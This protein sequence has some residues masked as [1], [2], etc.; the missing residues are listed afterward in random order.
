[1]EKY[2]LQV[3][4]KDAANFI[5]KARKDMIID[6][7]YLTDSDLNFVYIPLK[8]YQNGAVKHNF[9]LKNIPFL[10]IEEKIRAMRIK[11]VPE[12][13]KRLGNSIILNPGK[14]S[15]SLG[16]IYTSILHVDNVYVEA[17][18]IHGDKRTPSIK[19]LYGNGKDTEIT[20]N[21]IKYIINL[22]NLMFSPGNL[23][24]RSRMGKL[25]INGKTVID[26][27]AGIGY[28]LLPLLKYSNVKKCYAC[29]INSLSLEY[30]RKNIVKNKIGSNIDI[31]S[32]DCRNVIPYIGADYI[33]M[34][35]FKSINYLTAAL[36]RSHKFTV[37][38]MHYLSDE[39]EIY[40]KI[41]SIITKA[42]HLGYILGNIYNCRVKTVAPYYVHMNSEFIVAG[43]LQ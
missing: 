23:N 2:C 15:K 21:G 34:G 31:F 18:K 7:N 5:I 25:N 36:V 1:M 22:Q 41:K 19:L 3:P 26:M 20:E 13:Y 38:S 17:G 12:T 37:I 27:F 28:F 4:R 42:R 14:Y 40:E 30:L 16:A 8:T 6:D 24:T 35:N 10:K 9:K 43:I 33:I 32:G 39:S 29:D 11:I